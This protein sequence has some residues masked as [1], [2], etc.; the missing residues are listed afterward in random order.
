[1]APAKA[2]SLTD[3]AGSLRPGMPADVTVFRTESGEYT[4]AD[5]RS[6]TRT[7]GERIVP[8]MAFKDGVRVDSDLERCQDERNW[9]MEIAEDDVPAAVAEFSAAQLAFLHALAAELSSI[10]W[11][12]DPR[13][14]DIEKI[15]AL[16]NAVHRAR[17]RHGVTLAD[18]LRAVYGCFI[19]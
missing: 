8:I 13:G 15:S 14:M 5:C 12:V 4:L 6:K 11:E 7:A 9:F 17:A 16:Q 18:A 2:L 3:R 1:W 19:Y 10:E